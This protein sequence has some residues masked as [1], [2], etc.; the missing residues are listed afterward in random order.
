MQVGGT[1]AVALFASLTCVC[2]CCK[3]FL[4]CCIVCYSS[5]G[6]LF[7]KE[8]ILEYIITKKNEYYR[9]LKEYEKQKRKEEVIIILQMLHFN[10]LFFLC[11]MLRKKKIF[12][13]KKKDIV[14]EGGEG[15]T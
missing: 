11:C 5:D 15:I 9:K 14:M 10:V 1:Q 3:V 8:V 13:P 2:V 12:G 6:Y 4:K 7:D